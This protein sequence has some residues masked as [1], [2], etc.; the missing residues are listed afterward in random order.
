MSGRRDESQER[1]SERPRKGA[2]PV[3]LRDW[4]AALGLDPDLTHDPLEIARRIFERLPQLRLESAVEMLLETMRPTAVE[5]VRMVLARDALFLDAGSIAE[6][7]ILRMCDSAVLGEL[8]SVNLRELESVLR[9][10]VAES[11]NQNRTRDEFFAIPGTAASPANVGLMREIVRLVNSAQFMIRRALWLLWVERVRSL[12]L[13]AASTGIPLEH[14][15]HFATEIF[16]RAAHA[17]SANGDRRDLLG[18]EREE[19]S[20]G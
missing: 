10:T 20:D 18:R 9:E 12:D 2:R 7:V 5:Y 3:V 13:V 14:I 15:E 17:E 4:V 11:A 6:D 19:D 1:S 8:R 16:Q